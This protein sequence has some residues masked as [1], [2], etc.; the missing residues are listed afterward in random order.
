MKSELVKAR[1]QA[2]INVNSVLEPTAFAPYFDNL[3][4]SGK[5]FVT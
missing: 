5:M 4:G 2:N 3:L 1:Y